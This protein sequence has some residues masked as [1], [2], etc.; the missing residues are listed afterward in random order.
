VQPVKLTPS[1]SKTDAFLACQ[2]PWERDDIEVPGVIQNE[3]MSYGSAFHEAMAGEEERELLKARKAVNYKA[4]A[5]HW[6]VEDADALRKHVID[7]LNMMLKWLRKENPYEVDLTAGLPRDA[8]LIEKAVAF[9]AARGTARFAQGVDANH[10]Y[11]D[12]ELGELPGTLD[13]ALRLGASKKLVKRFGKTIFLLDHKTG[14]ECDPPGRSGQLKSLAC[15]LCKLWG[16]ERAIVAVMHTP[17]WGIPSVFS[18]ELSPTELVHHRRHLE[19]AHSRVGDGS[20]RPGQHCL[21]CQAITV[22]PVHGAGMAALVRA[23]EKDPLVAEAEQALAPAPRPVIDLSTPEGLGDAH[24]LLRVY[25][26]MRDQIWEQM[27]LRIQANGP[28]VKRNGKL[29]AIVKTERENL[30]KSSILKAYGPVDGARLLEEL[31]RREAITMV[32]RDELREVSD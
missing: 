25:D 12:R 19:I 5:E 10:V 6:R 14:Q 27:K 21:R 4:V 9:N 3:P 18:D 24:D 1:M 15:A 7:S 16:A 26:K 8:I 13:L 11:V 30:S 28:G 29:L 2:W 31:R 23:T 20:L 17:R 32:P 22:C